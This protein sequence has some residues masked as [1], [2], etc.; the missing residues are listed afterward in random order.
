MP[1][2]VPGLL[3]FL[4]LLPRVY[5]DCISP[6][7]PSVSTPVRGQA[8]PEP[9]TNAILFTKI[10]NAPCRPQ[11]PVQL[12]PRFPVVVFVLRFPCSCVT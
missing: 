10:D 7:A 6:P 11:P 9:T 1:W 5:H 4:V 8:P 2:T 12:H 3:I